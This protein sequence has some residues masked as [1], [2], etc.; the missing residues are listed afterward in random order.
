MIVADL[1]VVMKIGSETAEKQPTL[2]TSLVSS[3]YLSGQLN[4]T[5]MVW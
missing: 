1:P 3:F 4:A 5:A 2:N